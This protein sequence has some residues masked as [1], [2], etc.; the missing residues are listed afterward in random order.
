MYQHVLVATDGS[1]HATRAATHAIDVAAQYDATLHVVYVIETRTAFDSAIMDRDEVRENLEQIGEEALT[2]IRERADERD[3]EC[4]SVIE[5]G[6]PAERILAY[7]D[8]NDVDFVFLGERGHSAFKTVLL[9][10]TA[11]KVLYE[12]DVPVA[13]V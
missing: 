3:L 2:E 7:V 9:G 1:E 10:S 5:E 6:V 8:S 4:I 12:V 13:V 11:E